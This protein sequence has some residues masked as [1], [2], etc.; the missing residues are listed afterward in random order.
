MVYNKS[1]HWNWDLNSTDPFSQSNLVKRVPTVSAIIVAA[2]K[3]SRFQLYDSKK[4]F[5]VLGNSPVWL[6]SARQFRLHPNVGQMILVV[7]EEDRSWF[8]SDCASLIQDLEFEI[9]S[10]GSERADSVENALKTIDPAADYVAIHDAARPCINVGLINEVFERAI[11][12]GAAIPA[13]PVNSTVKKSLDGQ[14]ISETVDRDNLYLAQTPQ[15]FRRD[16]ILDAYSKRGGNCITDEAQL[17]EQNG[18]DVALV[19]GSSLNV[20]ITRPEDLRLAAACLEMISS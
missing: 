13:I 2:G 20:K 16:W 12:T 9:V 17:L 10:G 15:I 4:P 14:F 19:T 8:E 5:V 3:S 1:F 6:H 18:Y 11:Q 7:A